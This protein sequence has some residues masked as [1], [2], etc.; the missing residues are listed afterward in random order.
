MKKLLSSQKSFY[1]L[2][3]VALLLR[4]VSEVNN[5]V[6]TSDNSIQM[7][8]AKNYINS[9]SFTRTWVDAADL[10]QVQ[11]APMKL[12]PVGYP[13]IL[14]LINFFTGNLINSAI[15]FQ[16]IGIIFFIVGMVKLLRYFKTPIY[17]INLFLLLY[18]FNAAPFY[19]LGSTDLFTVSVFL[20]IIYYSLKAINEPGYNLK[21]ITLIAFLTFAAAAVR[22][23]CIPNIV[24]IPLF[25]AL[26]AILTRQ[27]I[28][29]T[30]AVL[31]FLI[32][33]SFV[34]LFYKIFPFDNTRTGFLKVLLS[35]DLYYSHMKWFDPFPLKSL[36]FTRPIEFHLPHNPTLIALYRLA[37]LFFSFGFLLFILLRFTKTPCLFRYIKN[38][39]TEP[40]NIYIHFTMLF[41]T[42]AAVIIGFI[43]MQ[44]L[45]TNP[46]TNSFGPSWMPPLWTFVYSTRYFIY[47]MAMVILIYFVAYF[48]SKE[49]RKIVR[50]IFSA[51][52]CVFF[53]W[54]FVY[55]LFISYQFYSPKG[56][57]AGSEWVNEKTGITA[58][59]EIKNI[60]AS[61]KSAHLVVAHYKDKMIEG[62]VTN[63]SDAYPTDDYKAIIEENFNNTRPVILVMIMPRALNNSE[64]NFL[65]KHPHKVLNTLKNE[66]II[67][68]NLQ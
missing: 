34:F 25:F 14:V 11:S 67:R 28:H 43:S 39:K 33:G 20:F 31:L 60:Q 16:C 4:I 3:L 15:V 59:N 24:I 7:E 65:N 41:I 27:K 13:F 38:I 32:S 18:A 42:T 49:D 45:T 22:L 62:L 66:Q 51:S 19:Y 61:D 1:F 53:L 2:L 63:Y 8:A 50:G 56:N 55:W 64:S 36:F 48:R 10:C 57:G 46:E 23:A 6:I 12:W 9:G 21:N 68:I 52:Y 58:Y 26:V 29:F 44:S 17:Y 35:G 40:S 30:K 5:P 54:A 37:L 47:L